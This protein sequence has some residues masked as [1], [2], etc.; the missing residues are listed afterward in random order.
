MFQP[1]RYFSPHPV[2]CGNDDGPGNVLIFLGNTTDYNS[3]LAYVDGL[4]LTDA[5][6]TFTI[7]EEGVIPFDSPTS[8]PSELDMS[9]SSYPSFSPTLMASAK[10]NVTVLI[11]FDTFSS[12]D[13]AWT[14]E[15]QGSGRVIYEVSFGTYGP[16]D[17]D[18][19]TEIVALELNGEYVFQMFDLGNDGL[20]CDS[21]E[22]YAEIYFG[23]EVVMDQ[24][25]LFER[26]DFTNSSIPLNFTVSPDATISATDS[27][28]SAPTL[29]AS[30]STSISP[31]V[32]M[33]DIVIQIQ[34][35]S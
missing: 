1:S 20:C 3:V 35:D 17:G 5:S 10:Q 23:N 34:F 28:S 32:P 16:Y 18:V 15:Q 29:S 9:L 6:T 2:C 8:A 31:T 21:G 19:I 11:N 22:G 26:G 14:I 33:I 27:P 25:L 7:S 13:I 30:P 12:V 4:F 24:L